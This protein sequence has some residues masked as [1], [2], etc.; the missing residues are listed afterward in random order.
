MQIV[1]RLRVGELRCLFNAEVIRC[2]VSH[3]Q[4]QEHYDFQLVCNR[5][6]F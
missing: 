3:I 6:K 2:R 5:E 4:S 1:R